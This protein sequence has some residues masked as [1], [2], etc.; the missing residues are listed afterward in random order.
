M[1]RGARGS[2]C[3]D[4]WLRNGVRNAVVDSSS[5]EVNRRARRAKTDRLD[6]TGLLRLLERSR[7]GEE[8]V[9]H[10]VRVPTV[11]EED[12]RHLHRQR[13]TLQQERTR[14]I[15]R[16]HGLL[17]TQG[18]AIPLHADFLNRLATVTGWDGTPLPAGLCQ[19]V[20][21]VWAQLG[22]LNAQLADLDAT[23]GGP[24][25]RIPRRRPAAVSRNC[26][27]SRG[28]ARSARGR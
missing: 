14:V 21:Y 4:I 10:V 20:R 15:N 13:E 7:E 12:A 25:A 18:V 16:L 9:W 5:I 2:G 3:I 27:R 8:R 1:R 19:R 23:L 11:A 24:G 22:F 17:T 28:S 6:L 26:R